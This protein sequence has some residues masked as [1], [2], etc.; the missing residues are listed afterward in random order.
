MYCREVEHEDGSVTVEEYTPRD[1]GEL[2]PETR[3]QIRTVHGPYTVSTVF[4]GTVGNPYETMVFVGDSSSDV[5]FARYLTRED[6]KKG[7]RRI[8]C[9]WWDIFDANRALLGPKFWEKVLPTPA[10]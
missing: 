4:L 3:W 1:A 9:K 6:A 5:D 2:D 10:F 8:S 7:H